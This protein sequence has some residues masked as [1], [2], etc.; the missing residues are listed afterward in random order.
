MSIHIQQLVQ[1]IKKQLNEWG[2]F[3]VRVQKTNPIILITAILQSGENYECY[4]TPQ[5]DS[6]YE[7]YHW[8]E[9]FGAFAQKVKNDE[10]CVDIVLHDLEAMFEHW[11]LIE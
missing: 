9:K 4:I 11:K 10:I 3:S 1:E 5:S 6:K 2:A 7:V 8:V